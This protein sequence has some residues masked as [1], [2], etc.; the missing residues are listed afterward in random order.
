MT[1]KKI[2]VAVIGVG[3]LGSLH[4]EKYASIEDAEL[5]GVVDI[6]ERRAGEVAAKLKTKAFRSLAELDGLVDAVSIVTPTNA[7]RKVGVDQLSKGVDVLIEKPI[8]MDTDEARSLIRE[9][10]KTGAIIQV[11]HLERFNGA[12]MALGDRVSNPMFIESNRL[13]P[14]PNRS[15]DV[16]VILDL[17]IHDIDIILNLV[18][19][20]VA[21]IDAIG[22]PVITQKV[23]VASAHIRFK[24]GCLANITASRV[25]N[26]RLREL[27]LFQADTCISIDYARQHISI[28]RVVPGVGEEG[29]R[30]VDEEID[31]EK[32]DSLMEE[33]K[34]FIKC[35][36]TKEKPLVSG[37][38][39]LNALQVATMVQEGI[40]LSMAG[41][42]AK[43]RP[44][45]TLV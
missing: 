1:M 32:K 14:F 21:D 35:S 34:A 16:D 19:S 36:A 40:E 4:A 5:V 24:N 15:T 39:G 42:T 27:R 12:V 17:M 9:G 25:S 2:R 3:H 20:E 38:E 18:D 37:T 41:F 43:N 31:I 11:G 23:D 44:P 26:N 29:P 7:H 30:M 28:A 6:D 10:E 22:I 13:S 8:A 45:G 33:L